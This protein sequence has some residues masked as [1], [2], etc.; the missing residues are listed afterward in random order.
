M[1]ERYNVII[2][3]ANKLK[4]GWRNENLYAEKRRNSEK[5]VSGRC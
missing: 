3:K 2:L 5:M 4:I 1:T